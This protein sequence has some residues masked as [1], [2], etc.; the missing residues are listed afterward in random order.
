MEIAGTIDPK[1]APVR[2]A[3]RENFTHR[4]ELGAAVTVTLN[5]RT[6]VDLW[7]GI[8]DKV[9]GRPWLRDTMVMVFSCTKAATALCAHVLAA[10]GQ[11]DLD[12]PVARYWPEF[13]A[14]GKH[15]MPVRLLLNHQAGLAAIDAPLPAAA[16]YDWGQMCAGLAAQRPHW[17]PGTAHGYHA[18]TFGWLVG[19][20]VRRI[21]GQ[22][23]GTFFR[24]VVAGPLGL[25]F[26]IGLPEM[27]E[28]RVAPVRMPRLGAEP[29]LFVLAM[30]NRASLTSK[31]FLN[32]PG[33]MMPGQV[34]SRAMRAAEVP[35]ANGV[36]TAR[37]LA[38]MYTALACGGRMRGIELVDG[39]TLQR[40]STLESAGDDRVLLLPTRFAAGFMKT[41]DNRPGDSL[42]LG[43]NP[44]AFGHGGA[45]GSIGM[46][47]PV[48]R[49]A[50]GYVM[51][52]M[53]AGIL[54]NPRGQALID[55][56][57]DCL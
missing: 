2:D 10:R 44:E 26:W 4:G 56:V 29:T 32:P 34:N 37:A 55:A 5:G 16:L 41:M 30:L 51:N 21:T 40:L 3:F 33:L 12:A 45:G 28:P 18:V 1:F 17:E 38:G 48:A 24:D 22:S 9:S 11:L 13:A 7:G 49:V 35:A 47:D 19:E 15:A 8:A 46:A 23:L 57:Y 43:P 20:I 39:A 27:L 6:V 36:A 14:A 53:G 42:I 50:I 54:L 52:Q 25:D 31:A